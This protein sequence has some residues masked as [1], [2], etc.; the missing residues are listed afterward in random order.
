MARRQLPTFVTAFST[1]QATEVIGEGGAGRVFGA[2][3]EAGEMY[4]VKLLSSGIQSR[5]RVRRFK[6]EILFGTQVRHPNIVSVTDHGV[7]VFEGADRPFYVMPRYP[8][9]LRRAFQGPIPHDKILP[10]FAQV[11]DGVEAAHLLGVVHRDLKPENILL[12]DVGIPLVAD[13]GIARFSAAHMA[14]TVETQPGDRL[15]NFIY[16]APEQLRAANEV[17]PATDLFA[18]GL[19]LN[20]AFTGQPPRGAGYTLIGAVAPKFSYLDDLVA[21]LISQ[22]VADRFP[23]VDAAKRVLIGRQE[24]FVSRQRLDA[25]RETVVPVQSV[26]DP[27]VRNPIELLSGNWDGRR[28]SFRLSQAPPGEWQRMLKQAMNMHYFT[29]FPPDAITFEGS[30]GSWSSSESTAQGQIDQFK[31]GM[32][33]ANTAYAAHVTQSAKNREAEERKRLQEAIKAEEQRQRVAS[34]LQF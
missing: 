13:F 7:L 22:Q 15:A 34:K 18:L 5:D 3:N 32:R 25:L 9:A 28:L 21:K 2:T 30:T 4:A 24:E 26:D 33:H 19:M 10:L 6:N 1:Y 16:A 14:T 11:L 23:S 27:A 12:N 31:A 8:S 29:N 20:E 17:T